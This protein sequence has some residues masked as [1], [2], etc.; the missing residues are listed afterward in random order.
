MQ[1]SFL[2]MENMPVL[3][4]SPFSAFA[5]NT[6]A[7]HEPGRAFLQPEISTTNPKQS[8]S[9]VLI[10]KTTTTCSG[11]RQ[12]GISEATLRMWQWKVGGAEPGRQLLTA[13]LPSARPRATCL[14]RLPFFSYFNSAT[15]KRSERK[16]S[17]VQ[18]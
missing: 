9:S 14:T 4:L 5:A 16:A 8:E 17:K 10:K 3:H 15:R 1:F 6:L 11:S 13:P 18:P 7:A 12:G 2:K